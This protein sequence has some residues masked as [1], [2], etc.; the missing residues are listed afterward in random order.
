FPGEAPA[1]RNTLHL[2]AALGLAEAG[3]I[4]QPEG[5][6]A[7]LD[8]RLDPIARGAR[9]GGHDRTFLPHQEV[10]Q[11]GLTG[12]WPARHDRSSAPFEE[13]ACGVAI[14]DSSDEAADAPHRSGIEAAGRRVVLLGVVEPRLGLRER[15]DDGLA[16]RCERPR[17]AALEPMER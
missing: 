5:K 15:V 12:V 3:G 17:E 13:P 10:E 11:T 2:D 7:Q 16:R 4:D 8:T 6:A 9:I 14:G 1:A